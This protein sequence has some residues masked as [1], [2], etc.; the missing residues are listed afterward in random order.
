M[1][2]A[3]EDAGLHRFTVDEYFR[4]VD[5]G[6][7]HED[8]RVELIHGVI[9][10]MSPI[11]RPHALAVTLARKLFDTGLSGRA[12][13]YEEKPMRLESLASV[14]EPDIC[15]CSNPDVM[16]YGTD[17]TK[18]LLV[19]EVADSTLRYDLSTKVQLYAE[20]EVPEYWVVD[21]QNE[22]LHVFREP[23][24]GAYQNRAKHDPTARIAPTAWPDFEID[25]AALFP[26]EAAPSP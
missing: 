16:A 5:A 4:M 13:V 12:S 25:V 21:L 3:A 24:D 2:S 9:L 17:S 10:E 6:I 1:A 18:A 19:V 11:N 7:L 22:A 20:A 26:T 8:D 23:Q 14:P 15:I